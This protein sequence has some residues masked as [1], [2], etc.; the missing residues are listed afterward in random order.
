[1]EGVKTGAVKAIC[2]Y[3]IHSFCYRNYLMLTTFSKS[4]DYSQ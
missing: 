1:M 3:S 2:G 4:A